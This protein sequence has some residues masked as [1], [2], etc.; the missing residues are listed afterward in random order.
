MKIIDIQLGRK[1]SYGGAASRMAQA[2]Q[3][4]AYAEAQSG[5]AYP[6]E[7]PIPETIANMMADA[8][9][10]ALVDSGFFSPAFNAAVV[11]LP[12]REKPDE[13]EANELVVSDADVSF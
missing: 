8:A 1:T 12:V 4:T 2:W 11:P 6:D 9:Y 10:K 13:P 7:Y 5:G 3:A